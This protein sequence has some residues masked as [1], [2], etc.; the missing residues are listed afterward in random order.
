MSDLTPAQL[1]AVA[2]AIAAAYGPGE[3]EILFAS[4]GEEF[5]ASTDSS[6]LHLAQMGDAV[7]D[8]TTRGRL[9]D[10]IVAARE[11]RFGGNVALQTA[12]RP[13][14]PLARWRLLD[15]V[16]LVLRLGPFVN[17]GNLRSA[18]DRLFLG[19]RVL[20]IAGTACGRS[21]SCQLIERQA[22]LSGARYFL[23]DLRTSPSE[24]RSDPT[25][26]ATKLHGE[27]F[28]TPVQP[29]S[30]Q[31]VAENR[32]VEPL[33]KAW[34]PP[35]DLILVAIDHLGDTTIAQSVRD[36]VISLAL[37]VADDKLPK[38]RLI[39][40][41]GPPGLDLSNYELQTVEDIVGS[42][43]TAHLDDFFDQAAKTL[44]PNLRPADL[45]A[46]VDAAA[47]PVKPWAAAGMSKNLARAVR[48]S[49]EAM[50]TG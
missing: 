49:L 37:A 2:R 36:Y 35:D 25:W 43:T 22:T 44:Y 3:A 32:L 40:I 15:T 14:A 17:R 21:W 38:V 1:V 20:L 28:V 30:L 27:L 13:I 46:I 5:Q 12:L 24:A 9:F 29:P 10:L 33:L 31:G 48:D 23:T 42:V 26:L 34:V 4:I 18:V 50:A 11:G 47:T 41:D 6:Q 7:A 39:L 16:G 19:R 45:K 8:L